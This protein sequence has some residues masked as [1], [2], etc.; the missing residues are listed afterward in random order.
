MDWRA[1][2]AQR[3]QMKTMMKASVRTGHP[4]GLPDRVLL[5]FAPNAPLEHFKSNCK[6]KKKPAV[7]YS[8][9]GAYVGEFA[10]PG[11]AEYQP[12]PPASAAELPEPR[13]FANKEYPLQVQ[14]HQETRL[15]KCG[16]RRQ[17]DGL[18]CLQQECLHMPLPLC[19]LGSTAVAKPICPP[20][21]MSLQAE[22]AS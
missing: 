12:P 14:L 10:G 19:G 5:L 8:G 21:C 9:I 22:T 4:T 17:N 16:R 1:K 7:P 3:S 15:E 20:L 18:P 6:P 11:D 2:P 13:I